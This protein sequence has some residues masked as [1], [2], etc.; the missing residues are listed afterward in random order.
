MLQIMKNLNTL[1][2]SAISLGFIKLEPESFIVNNLNPKFELRPYQIEAFARFNYYNSYYP[3]RIMPAHLLFHMATGS[4]KTLIMAGLILDLYKKG[5]RNFIFF[6]NSTSIIEKTKD[7]FLNSSS[8][9]YLYNEVI[10]IEDRT[11]KIVEVDNFE[12]V[13][14][15]DINIFFT[16]VQGLHTKLNTPRENSITYEDFEDK[17]VVL[18]SDEAHHINADTKKGKLSKDETE[19]IISWESTVNKIFKTNL[20]NYL[21]EFTATSDLD[22]ANIKEKY[23]D[24]LIFDYPLK[25]FR[26][27][28]YSKEVQ[29]LQA[30]LEPFERALQAVILSQYRRKIFQDFKKNI[31][32]VI[33]LKSKT[34]GESTAFFEE[35]IERIKS[36]KESDIALIENK[37]EKGIFKKIFQYLADNKISFENLII[38]IKEEFNIDKCI[39]VNSKN[40]TDEKQLI[41]NSLEDKTNEYR[42]VFAVDKLNEGWDV[43]NLFDIVRLYNT[44]DSDHKAGKIGKT[45]MSE[46]Q[47]IGRGARYCPFQLDDTQALF[48]RKYDDDIEHPLR[49]SEE[50][51]YHSA[52]NPKYISE[53]NKALEEI[54]LKASKM[55]QRELKL[56][57]SFKKSDFYKSGLIY[58]NERLPYDRSDILELPEELRNKIFKIKFST[59]YTSTSRI[60]ESDN[61]QNSTRSTK[62]HDINKFGEPVIRKAINKLPFYRFNNLQ[63]YFPKLKSITEFINSSSFL[64]NLKIEIDG[65]KDLVEIPDK[66]VQLKS[67]ISI[68]Q[69]IQEYIS[70]GFIEFKGS[71][72]F[73]SKNISY[74]FGDKTLNYTVNE[75]EDSEYGKPQTNASETNIYVDLSQEDWYAYNDNFGTS[76]EKYLVKFIRQAYQA[77]KNKYDDIFLLRNENH[78]KLFNFEDGKVF[79]PDFVFFM[80][81][82][83]QIKPIIF[84]TFI[85]PKGDNLLL[86]DKWKQDFLLQ[87]AQ[88]ARFVELF[89]NREYRLI[90]LPFYNEDNLKHNFDTIF[91][92]KF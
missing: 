48:Q 9:K 42:V 44:R 14:K 52:H 12:A 38:E 66:E 3:N 73:K 70:N 41:I 40:D 58:V 19:E 77:L 1:I 22:N 5:Y 69:E 68:L 92:D 43:L 28:K 81:E 2:S 15:D 26:I 20:E 75:S 6:V 57:E 35:F 88:K 31:K 59:G 18:I 34:I 71:F 87:I 36:L 21:L 80:K 39:S 90:G 11:I 78:F 85:E 27:D 53:L 63:R 60:F 49:V 37:N 82:S 50:L 46:A 30:D 47:L 23:E 4:G 89:S 65:S 54:G 25:Q 61:S 45:T 67:V 56:K 62:I 86:T 72:E 33:L 24:K 7:N 51:Y 91:W 84:Q 55:I 32:P 64:Q 79:E 83:S 10:S 29:L 74:V 76:E 16:T 8:S 17:K 13:N